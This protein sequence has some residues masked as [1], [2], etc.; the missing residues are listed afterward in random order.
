[1]NK[2]V[3]TYDTLDDIKK[4]VVDKYTELRPE[5][6]T[7]N[8]ISRQLVEDLHYSLV[9]KRK[10]GEKKYGY[11]GW[12]TKGPKVGRALYHWPGKYSTPVEGLIPTQSEEEIQEHQEFVNELAENGI[13]L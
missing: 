4:R 6:A 9:S 1:M 13:T 11:P 12:I 5:L 10:P 2:T 7:A 3:L 8:S